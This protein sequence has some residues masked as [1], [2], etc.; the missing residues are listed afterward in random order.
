[1]AGSLKRLIAVVRAQQIP[2]SPHSAR[3]GGGGGD[4]VLKVP[5]HS[6]SGPLSIHD[7]WPPV[8]HALEGTG[9]HALSSKFVCHN[10][11][12]P[13]T[14]NFLELIGDMEVNMASGNR[15]HVVSTSA[16]Y[17]YLGLLAN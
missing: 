2:H 7:C 12:Q 16:I 3:V 4:G 17:K 1:M 9:L 13:K 8:S 11:S 15:V 10:G 6:L 14:E 5:Q